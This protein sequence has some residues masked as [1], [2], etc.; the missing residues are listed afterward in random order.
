MS[1]S[2]VVARVESA[3]SEVRSENE[4]QRLLLLSEVEKQRELKEKA[5]RHVVEMA[6]LVKKKSEAFDELKKTGDIGR[7]R[8]IEYQAGLL[9]VEQKRRSLEIRL[10][11]ELASKGVVGAAE[12]SVRFQLAAREAA[13]AETAGKLECARLE[14][15]CGRGV[16]EKR[17]LELVASR[18]ELLEKERLVDQG[19]NDLQT[20]LDQTL[21]KDQS[22]VGLSSL[23]ESHQILMDKA[24]IVY[25]T[26]YNGIL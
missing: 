23:V 17:E 9:E 5:D 16:L 18:E 15:E 26:F 12:A 7:Q 1:E 4:V 11:A 3:R 21:E 14:L 10:E 25:P 22:L 6:E 24:G 8:V 20:L 2:D 19:Q 13:L